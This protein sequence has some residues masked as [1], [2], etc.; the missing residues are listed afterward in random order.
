MD[1]PEE[2]RDQIRWATLDLSGPYK[3]AFDTAL[4]DAAQIADPFHVVR[5]AN[6]A[7]DEV[8]QTRTKRH[9]RTTA[10]AKPV[11]L[12]RV[13]KL[14]GMASELINDDNRTKLLGLPRCR[15]PPRRGPRRLATPTK[16]LRS[17]YDIDD[18]D[19][20]VEFVTQVAEDLQ[21]PD[22]APELNRLGRT[23]SRWCIQI[24]NWHIARVTN[25]ATK[26]SQQR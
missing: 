14:L 4:P 3:A 25:A 1:Q 16:L 8:S 10:S 12:C 24:T 13:R 6:Q 22:L 23:L 11:P 26:H 21:D 5:V 19:T 2:W 7:L 9:P 18:P 20:A 17:V 15:R